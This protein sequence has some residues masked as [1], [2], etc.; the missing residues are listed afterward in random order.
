MM[1]HR[2]KILVLLAALLPL[3]AGSLCA[4]G[5]ETAEIRTPAPAATPQI[6]GPTLFGVRPNAPFLYTIPATG[7]R[8][9]RYAVDGLPKGLSV[10]AD[11]GQISG[12]IG[13]KGEYKV[14]L[15]ASNALGESQKSFRIV[16]G[17]GIAL[18]PPMGWNSYNCWGHQIDQDKTMRTAKAMIESGLADH[19]WTYVN[20][21]D[22]WQGERGGQFNAILPDE[23]FGD[24][25]ALAD[26][27]HAMGLKIG[28]YSS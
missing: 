16:C 14:T 4:V 27:I 19:G 12:K 28:I 20:I 8:P 6:N 3:T 23:G 22:G 21:D 13:S 5:E 17:E 2:L 18:T 1:I 26:E 25:K 10:N 15:R 24:M 7:Q 11:N 9:M